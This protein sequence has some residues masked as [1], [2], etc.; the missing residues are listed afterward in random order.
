LTHATIFDLIR[1]RGYERKVREVD[2]VLLV[3]KYKLRTLEDQT[4]INLEE[5]EEYSN[6]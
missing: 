3:E 4:G 6:S 5:H 1:A 2:V